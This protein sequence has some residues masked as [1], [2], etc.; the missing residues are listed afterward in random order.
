MDEFYLFLNSGD[1]L[2]TH[3]NNNAG[4]FVIDLPWIFKLQGRWECALVELTFF[5]DFETSDEAHLRLFRS[6]GRLMCNEHIDPSITFRRYLPWGQY[7][8]NVPSSLLFRYEEGRIETPA[9]FYKR[10][11]AQTLSFEKRLFLLYATSMTEMGSLEVYNHKDRKWVLY[12]PDIKKWEQYFVDVSTE[13]VF[14]DH[15][16]RYIIGSGSRR[17]PTSQQETPKI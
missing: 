5:P 17:R 2:T 8:S 3:V 9:G 16:G 4:D 14:P 12:V 7:V 11:P 15:K 6:D 13:L 1:S 10:R